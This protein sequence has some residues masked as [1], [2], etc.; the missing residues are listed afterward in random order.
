MAPLY[1]HHLS[2]FIHF[3]AEA[4]SISAHAKCK[5]SRLF[6][7][8]EIRRAAGIQLGRSNPSCVFLPRYASFPASASSRLQPCSNT[9]RCLDRREVW[10]GLGSGGLGGG[11]LADIIVPISPTAELS[12]SPTPAA[13]PVTFIQSFHR[14]H[15]RAPFFVLFLLT[16]YSSCLSFFYINRRGGEGGVEVGVAKELLQCCNAAA[17]QSSLRTFNENN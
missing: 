17:L 10:E 13:A 8:K 12:I 9:N 4:E 2:C 15:P 11:G 1:L 14:S 3:T 7:F 16:K 5:P 6:A